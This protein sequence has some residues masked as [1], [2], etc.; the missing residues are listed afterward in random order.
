VFR[1]FTSLAL[2]VALFVGG[3]AVAAD[4]PV[5]GNITKLEKSNDQVIITVSVAAKK[6]K[7][8]SAASETKIEKKYT[9]AG[10]T[11]VEKL[12]GKKD[13]VVRSDGKLDDLKE[14]QAIT[15]TISG[16]KVEKVE[17]HSAKKKNK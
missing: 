14:G 11:K 2:A 7:K 8:D 15:L 6:K 1:L 10:S 12:V 4:K 16:D 3:S 17:F 5:K 9:L 13:N